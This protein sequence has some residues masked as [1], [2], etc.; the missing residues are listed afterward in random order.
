LPGVLSA[1]E[2]V[3]WYN[4]HPKAASLPIDLSHISSV[5]IC[6]VGNVALDIARLLLGPVN[7]FAT[8][9]VAAHTMKQLVGGNSVTDVHIV[10]RRGPVQV[11][12]VFL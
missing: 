6:G 10:A 8:T 11:R 2:F 1:R 9:D 5:A 7:R 12:P 4:A 3:W